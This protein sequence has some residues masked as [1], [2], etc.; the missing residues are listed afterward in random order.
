VLARI[1]TFS[2][3]GLDARPVTVEVDIRQGLPAFVIVGLGDAAV[4]EARERVRA[5][6]QNAGLEFP[7]RRIV[8]NLAP[9]HLRKN[10]SSLDLPI[11]CGVLAA[12]GQLAP[13]PLDE[14][15]VYGEV[16][17]TGDLRGCRGTLAVAQ[18]AGRAGLRGIVVARERARE[19][20]LVDGLE[21]AGL[22][23]LSDIP[24]LLR[25][26]PPPPVPSP[27][28]AQAPAGSGD[29]ALDLSDVRGHRTPIAALRV[30]AAGGH[31]LLMVGGPGTGKTML[32][33]RLPSI[34][35]PMSRQEA[36]DV[37]RIHSIAGRHGGGGLIEQRPFR[38]PHHTI[39]ASGLVGGGSSPAPGEA[40]LAHHGVLF[41]DE[42]SEFS[43]SALEALRQPVEDG[44]IAVVRG[45]H[46]AVFP[47]Q[48][49]LVAATNPCPCG[50]ATESPERC[51]CSAGDVARYARR[52]SGPLLDRMDMLTAVGRP[53]AEALAAEPTTDSATVREEVVAARERQV[54]RFGDS[55]VVCNAQMSPALVR[56]HVRLD[57]RADVELASAYDQTLL[58]A[59]GHVRTL[60]VARTLADLDGRDRV[61]A[62]HVQQ[63]LHLRADLAEPSATG[64]AAAA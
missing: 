57:H 33:R 43:R 16:S 45:Q 10:G 9:A 56:R 49:M 1:H 25:G 11:A 36:V 44:R 5:A 3:Q 53:T 59:R 15:A 30:A 42:L 55:G 31:N 60:K 28:G 13:E 52:L 62:L 48:F 41:L 61:A 17:L 51:R 27:P 39:S 21:V 47:T 2:I 7:L 46:T 12:S 32:A 8:A 34:L 63:A 19:A 35:P 50:F 22:E 37:T 38:A 6:I 14:L 4:R 24:A 64:E 58:S 26:E 18:A 40:S 29:D 20:A 23:R 54:A